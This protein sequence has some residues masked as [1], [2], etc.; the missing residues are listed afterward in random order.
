MTRDGNSV[1][2]D[3]QRGRMVLNNV[4]VRNVYYNNIPVKKVTFDGHN[5]RDVISFEL[6]ITDDILDDDY[7]VPKKGLTNY[8]PY[9]VESYILNTDGTKT[10][11]EW[12]FGSV[13][14]THTITIPRNVHGYDIDIFIELRQYNQSGIQCNSYEL[15]LM[16]S[17]T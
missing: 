8:V 7:L 10:Q 13:R 16:Q 15:E 12:S 5:V 14:N 3:L 4:E 9:L 17:G 11:L 2:T 6:Y 1:I